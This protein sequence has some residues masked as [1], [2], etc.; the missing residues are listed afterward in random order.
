MEYITNQL[1]NCTNPLSW[2]FSA[3]RNRVLLHRLTKREIEAKYK[4]SAFGF[5]WSILTPLLLLAV[6]TFVFSVIFNARWDNQSSSK[7]EFALILFSGLIVFNIFSECAT[8]APSLMLANVSYIKRVVFPLEILPWVIVLSALFQATINLLVLLLGYLIAIGL[9]PLTTLALPLSFLPIIMISVGLGLFFSS[10][11]VYF[12]D[13]QQLVSVFVMIVMFLTP[14][15]YPLSAIPPQF[16]G[17][18]ALNPI[19]EII[20]IFR[21][22]IFWGKLPSLLTSLIVFIF[23]WLTAWFGF[24]WF[25]KTKKGFA[26]VV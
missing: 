12:R 14:I 19:S 11:G 24:S 18:I 22:L 10:V 23:S 1:D 2:I 26:D 25:I 4:G 13:L 21:N 9:P 6:Y 3:W 20:E 15:F 5:L 17:L 16:R 8:R 7:V